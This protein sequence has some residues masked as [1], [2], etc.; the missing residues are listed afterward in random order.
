M[1]QSSPQPVQ[2]FSALALRLVTF[3]KVTVSSRLPF[4]FLPRASLFLALSSSAVFP[5]LPPSRAPL[6][7]P[8]RCD[9][10]PFPSWLLLPCAALISFCSRVCPRTVHLSCSSAFWAL[11][12]FSPRCVVMPSPLRLLPAGT[13]TSTTEE[14]RFWF[15][16]C[17]SFS[18]LAFACSSRCASS[19]P[20][21][22]LL[23]FPWLAHI[24]FRNLLKGLPPIRSE[25]VDLCR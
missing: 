18:C 1:K 15:P 21:L 8:S 3:W 13:K 25:D 24:P 14:S 2:I 17:S 11:S 5:C 22:S 20:S 10:A 6:A 19:A 16:F 23:L 9:V 12:S 7:T 4:P